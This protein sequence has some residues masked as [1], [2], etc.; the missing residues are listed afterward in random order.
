V[1]ARLAERAHREGFNIQ[2]DIVSSLEMGDESWIAP[3]RPGYYERDLALLKSLPNITHHGSLPNADVLTLLRTAHFSLLPTFSDSFGYSAIESMA[4]ATPVIATAQCALPEFI[5]DKNGVLLPLSADSAG[6]WAHINVQ[7]DRDTPA[8]EALFDAEVNGLV[9]I[10]FTRLKAAAA[11]R[12]A[13][14]ALRREARATAE[15]LF[16]AESATAF[17]DDFY[18]RAVKGVVTVSA[19]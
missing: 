18:D 3:T 13:Y 15:R 16:A 12:E 17:W 5:N 6:E 8:Y 2:I 9:D 7:D 11:S 4:N 14:L 10:A 19:A 1:A